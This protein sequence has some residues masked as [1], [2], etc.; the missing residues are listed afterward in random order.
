MVERRQAGRVS[1]RLVS[2]E[3]TC[4][5]CSELLIM[6]DS[7][8]GSIVVCPQCDGEVQIPAKTFTPLRPTTPASPAVQ[9][10]SPA[11]IADAKRAKTIA[12]LI[13]GFSDGILALSLISGGLIGVWGI[14]E[15][16]PIMAW[17]P[18]ALGIIGAGIVQ[19]LGFSAASKIVLLLADLVEKPR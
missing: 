1:Y 15:G 17:L 10:A 3:A 14:I 19:C 8:A 9:Y 16:A 13:G 18:A 12:R 2:I 6:E 11:H 7:V 5:K 4:P